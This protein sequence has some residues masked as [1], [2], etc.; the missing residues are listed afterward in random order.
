LNN[1][2]VTIFRN[3]WNHNGRCSLTINASSQPIA[4]LGWRDSAVVRDIHLCRRL[5]SGEN[6][7]EV[8]YDDLGNPVKR[9]PLA[10]KI[11]TKSDLDEIFLD[12]EVEDE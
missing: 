1:E 12:L 4:L 6:M 10:R 3:L 5:S 7:Q 8:V 11:M 9:N 2:L